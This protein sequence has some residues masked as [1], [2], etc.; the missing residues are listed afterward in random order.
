MAY[1]M[2]ALLYETVPSF[3]K[4]WIECLGDL[5]RYRMAVEE[6]CPRDREVWAGV[7]R[8]WYSQAADQMP[9]VGRL[10]HHLAILARPNNLQQLYLYSRALTSTQAF[11]SAR[12]SIQ[13]LFDPVM[14]DGTTF[15]SDIDFY[16]IQVHAML[17]HRRINDVQKPLKSFYELLDSHIEKSHTKWRELGVYI[18]VSNLC[19][20]FDYGTNLRLR[21]V[22][23]IGNQ[24][25]KQEEP[26][27]SLSL[28]ANRKEPVSVDTNILPNTFSLARDFSFKTF[29]TILTRHGDVNVHP[30]VHV[31]LAFL[32][33]LASF[34]SFR[35]DSKF[36]DHYNCAKSI[37]SRVPWHDLCHFLNAIARSEDAGTPRYETIHFIRPAT[38][39]VTP[40]PEDHLI[41]GEVFSQTYFPDDWF[42]NTSS[43]DEQRS[44]EHA[45]TVKMRE[46]RIRWLGYILSTVSLFRT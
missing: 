42:R 43:E 16:F 45:S 26:V 23:E 6:D 30:S 11:Y 29:L 18:T 22:F 15:L 3:K 41:R 19:A 12:E 1:Q 44:I 38:E 17:Y 10:Y 28:E 4:T 2:M 33:S 5:S 8:F 31:M 35:L 37:L 7:A 36:P 9:T 40:L 20:M 25:L 13:I 14:K 32:A 27:I 39:D 46:E 21:Q 24:L 34:V